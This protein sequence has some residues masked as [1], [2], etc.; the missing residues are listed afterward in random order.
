ML[1]LIAMPISAHAGPTL[2]ELV[3]IADLDSLSISPDGKSVVFRIVRPSVDRNIVALDWFILH[4]ESGRMHAPNPLSG[5]GD[6][7]FND[8]G[9]LTTE[10]PVW[11]PDSRWIYF[12]KARDGAVQVWRA[13]RDGRTQEQVTNL[14]A[15]VDR[16][17][18]VNNGAMLIAEHG[19]DRS[20]TN[21]AERDAY[22]SGVLFDGSIDPG[23]ALFLGGSINGRPATQRL[24]GDWF[25]RW[26]LLDGEARQFTS[27][28]L[29][30]HASAAATGDEID[31]FQAGFEATKFEELTSTLATK[32]TDGK[33]IATLSQS[34]AAS[35]IHVAE[36]HGHRQSFSCPPAICGTGYVSAISWRRDTTSLIV[37][38]SDKSKGTTL[39]LW[40]P[41]ARRVKRLVATE[42]RLFGDLQAGSSCPSAGERMYCV[43]SDFRSPPSLV[44]VDLRRGA[45]REIFS[46]NSAVQALQA[47][48]LSWRDAD[49]HDFSGIY[50]PASGSKP[51]NGY[52]IFIN[53]Y[54]CAGYLK[55]GVGNEYPFSVLAERGVA[56]L[57]INKVSASTT[58]QDYDATS[59]Y[60]VGLTGISA[61]VEQLFRQGRIDKRKVG[62][63]GLSFG[64]EVTAWVAMKSRLLG[65]ASISSG[66]I[67]PEYFWLN[68]ARNNAMRANFTKWWR[69]DAP[70]VT[71]GRWK[72]VSPALNTESISIP[73]LFQLSEQEYRYN[74]ELFGRL[75]LRDR[76]AT[77]YIYPDEAHIKAQPRHKL[78]VYERNLAWFEYWLRFGGEEV[79]PS[80]Q[81]E[82]CDAARGLLRADRLPGLAHN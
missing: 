41:Q 57:C 60:Q 63:G 53:Y 43:F 58:G 38:V 21:R 22:L 26:G 1:T 66:L 6:A 5:G 69:L 4:L 7:V 64:A 77:M 82:R 11:S 49:G 10:R 19:P 3:E 67:E 70:D 62:M 15:D 55:G 9:V 47:T 23:Q 14:A 32:S 73:V 28:N 72:E 42:G 36:E 65:A 31:A 27:I 25:D 40:R 75:V 76:C 13:S 35:S 17:R 34:G 20:A 59:D 61:I 50:F 33:W 51:A 78:A 45:I 18:I 12:R 80:V 79:D 81:H 56:A 16:F 2:R 54:N 30:T 71:P 37:F 8:V 39:F 29:V 44:E 68:M 48:R 74:L 52:P 46:P 24:H